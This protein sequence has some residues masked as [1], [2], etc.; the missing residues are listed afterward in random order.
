MQFTK[1][2][3]AVAMHFAI[4]LSC[5]FILSSQ[6]AAATGVVKILVEVNDYT[7]EKN[8]LKSF[9]GTKMSVKAA[10]ARVGR[11][12]STSAI[13]VVCEGDFKAGYIADDLVLSSNR[14]NGEYE[15]YREGTLMDVCLAQE[16]DYLRKHPR[17]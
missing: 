7:S 3:T 4:P 9:N 6:V 8:P 10:L 13:A 15:A 16:R 12:K 2:V 1:T 11:M 14:W 17:R 5:L